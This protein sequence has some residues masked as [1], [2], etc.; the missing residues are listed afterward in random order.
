MQSRLEETTMAVAVEQLEQTHQAL[1]AAVQAGDWEQVGEL[2]VLCREL[3]GQAML[4]PARD[5]RALAEALTSLSE[6]YREVIG[7]CQAVQGK[8]AEELHGIQRSK[9]SAKVYQMFS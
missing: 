7:L 3:V 4:N 1:I 2:D 9:E 6:T 5:E 8:L